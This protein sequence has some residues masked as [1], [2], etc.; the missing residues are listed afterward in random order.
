MAIDGTMGIVIATFGSSEWLEKAEEAA[1]SVE[2]QTL[3]P[4]NWI[5]C[6]DSSLAKARNLGAKLV[7]TDWLI[8]LDADDTLDNRYVEEMKVADGGTLLQPSTLGV[9]EDGSTDEYPVVIS[10]KPILESNYLVIGTMCRSETFFKV[11][12]FDDSLPA[13][14]DWDLWIRMLRKGEEDVPVPNAVYRVGVSSTGR[15]NAVG[16]HST[17]YTMIKRK[18]S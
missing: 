14:E 18:Y 1:A 17:A 6:H 13:L 2:S 3:L 9:Y 7:G 15:N 16:A 4:D 5:H 8:F 10:K 11:G 12:G